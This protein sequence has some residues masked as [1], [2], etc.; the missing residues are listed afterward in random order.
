MRAYPK[1]LL[2]CGTNSTVGDAVLSQLYFGFLSGADADEFGDCFG[3][4][5]LLGAD[6]VDELAALDDQHALR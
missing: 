6:F 2:T 5:E 1:V 4:G 3:V